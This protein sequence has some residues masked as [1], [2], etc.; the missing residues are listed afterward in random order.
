MAKAENA[1][2]IKKL[3]LTDGFMAAKHYRI[4]DTVEVYQPDPLV[5]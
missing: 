1:I 3:T 2:I 5:E 4:W